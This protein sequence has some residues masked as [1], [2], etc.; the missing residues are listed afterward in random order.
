MYELCCFYNNINK[1][2]KFVIFE[3]EVILVL[4][5]FYVL[6]IDFVKIYLYVRKGKT[7]ICFQN[8]I[9]LKI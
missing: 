7:C 8:N 5:G 6:I 2:Q 9:N 1:I 4:V 3:D